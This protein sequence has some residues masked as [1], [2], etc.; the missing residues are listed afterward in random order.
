MPKYSSIIRKLETERE[1]KVV[2]MELDILNS[3]IF[4]LFGDNFKD[5]K[6]VADGLSTTAKVVR[7]QVLSA[8]RDS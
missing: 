7:Y 6:Y 2:S 5:T 8:K 3:V 4:L 1:V